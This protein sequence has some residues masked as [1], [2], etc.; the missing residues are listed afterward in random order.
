MARTILLNNYI[1]A[2]HPSAFA[3]LVDNIKKAKA[4]AAEALT[5][6]ESDNCTYEKKYVE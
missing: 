4:L 6:L 3:E 1:E 2:V 5:E